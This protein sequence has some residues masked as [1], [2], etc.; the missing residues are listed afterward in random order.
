LHPPPVASYAALCAVVPG[1]RVCSALPSLSPHPVLPAAL[2]AQH[3]DCSS[4]PY[5]R[6]SVGV[7]RFGLSYCT[8]QYGGLSLNAEA[9]GSVT[10]A[11]TVEALSRSVRAPS[12]AP[13]AYRLQP[14]PTHPRH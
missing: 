7:R 11:L 13:S 10:V 3:R 9:D 6:A 12:L 8:F 1:V 14:A 5:G 2:R 4:C